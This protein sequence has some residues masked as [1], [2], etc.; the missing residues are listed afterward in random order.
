MSNP[1]GPSQTEI[2]LAEKAH[3]DYLTV[4]RAYYGEATMYIKPSAPGIQAEAVV[5]GPY[6]AAPEGYQV[7]LNISRAWTYGQ[8]RQRIYA[9][10]RTLPI[11]LPQEAKA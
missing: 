3:A 1:F 10:L 5:L 9:A 8:T 7:A 11:I 2:R 4:C 6:D